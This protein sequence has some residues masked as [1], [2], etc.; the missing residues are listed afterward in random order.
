MYKYEQ[1]RDIHSLPGSISSKKERGEGGRKGGRKR[2]RGRR[3]GGG[4]ERER[5]S[6]IQGEKTK[7]N[8][9]WRKKSPIWPVNPRFTERIYTFRKLKGLKSF[10]AFTHRFQINFNVLKCANWQA[11]VIV[12]NTRAQ[13][14][15]TPGD[16]TKFKQNTPYNLKGVAEYKVKDQQGCPY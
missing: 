1:S 3:E 8:K 14:T 12:I 9:N 11:F 7:Q 15:V 2:K 13:I 6:W 4:I 10:C 16:P 5:E